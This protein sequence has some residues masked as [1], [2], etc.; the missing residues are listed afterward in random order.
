MSYKACFVF[1][2]FCLLCFSFLILLKGT[3]K[4][5]FTILNT[6]QVYSTVV[7]YSTLLYNKSLEHLHLAKLKFPLNNN[8][9]PLPASHPPI[10]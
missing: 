3:F 9:F 5:K 4:I 6:F 7:N 2:H 10:P 1:S 8:S